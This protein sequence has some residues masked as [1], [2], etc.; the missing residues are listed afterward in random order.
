L[1]TFEG[2]LEDAAARAAHLQ[3]IWDRYCCR[4]LAFIQKRVSDHHDAEDLLQE[5]F[6]RIHGGLCCLREWSKLEAWMYQ[7]TRNLI[8]DYYRRRKPVV[9]IPETVAA[10]EAPLEEDPA[11]RIAV[12]LKDMVSELPEPY[13]QA[14]VL[15]EYQGLSQKELAEAQHISLS[16]AKSRVQR[17]RARLRDMLLACCHFELDRRGRIIDYHRRCCSCARSA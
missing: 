13:R 17:A 11:A 15:T 8:I 1:K 5:A 7:V 6:I 2:K 12:S 9:E 16:G 4:L 14:L 3:E 10:E